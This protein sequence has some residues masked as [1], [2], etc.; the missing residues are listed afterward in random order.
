MRF[1]ETCSGPS[2]RC[3]TQF[4][5]SLPFLRSA[6]ADVFRKRRGRVRDASAAV[7]V[8]QGV[9]ALVLDDAIE[10]AQHLLPGILVVGDQL[11]ER[12]LRGL[13]DRRAPRV[14]VAH[15]PLEGE[16]ST[17]GTTA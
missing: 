9:D 14:E 15:E 16:P 7:A 17:S 10:V 4:F 5:S 3:S 2:G 6:A 1:C 13:R 12:L 11:G 8:A